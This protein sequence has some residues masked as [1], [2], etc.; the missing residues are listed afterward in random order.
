MVLINAQSPRRALFFVV[1]VTLAVCILTQLPVEAANTVPG[2]NT[3][4]TVNNVDGQGADANSN[5]RAVSADGNII[6][7]TSASSNLGVSGGLYQRNVLAGTTAAMSMSTA[8][9]VSVGDIVAAAMSETGRYVAFTTSATG[10][11]DGVTEPQYQT[12]VRD[13]QAGTTSIITVYPGTTTASG[14]TNTSA[15][16]YVTG[17]SN[18][19]RFVTIE[20]KVLAN[21]QISSSMRTGYY[22]VLL[23]DR[24]TGTWQLLNPGGTTSSVQTV[25]SRMSCDGSFVVLLQSRS[26][27]LADIRNASTPTVSLIA[28]STSYRPDISCNGDYIM[29]QTQNR[30][31]ITPTPSGMS[32][33]AHVVRYNRITGERKYI[34]SDSAGTTYSNSALTIYTADAEKPTPTPLYQISDAGDAVVS[35]SGGVYLKHLSDASGTLEALVKTGST[36]YTNQGFTYLSASGKYTSYSYNAYTLDLITSNTGFKDIVRSATG[37]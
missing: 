29:Y 24:A 22:D 2:N 9:T 30:S 10:L 32:S 4:V 5:V 17:I 12:Y 7:F 33:Y 23:L 19:G 27:Y 26:V 13:M 18:D 8:G 37:L 6:L 20:S 3:L 14:N 16:D 35:Y 11:I 31:D 36:S 1:A 15:W 21:R 34:D 25:Q 28:G